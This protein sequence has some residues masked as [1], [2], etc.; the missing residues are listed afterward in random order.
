MTIPQ[1]PL[2]FNTVKKINSVIAIAIAL[3]ALLFIA[4][5]SSSP[6]AAPAPAPP[7]LPVQTVASSQ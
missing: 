7:A 6:A 1:S 5:C 4:G 2:P 3:L